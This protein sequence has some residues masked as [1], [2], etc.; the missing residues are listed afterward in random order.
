[1]QSNFLQIYSSPCHLPAFHLLPLGLVSARPCAVGLLEYMSGSAD[2]W[3]RPYCL[4]CCVSSTEELQV[5][6]LRFGL[7]SLT[8]SL[9]H[10]GIGS[11]ETPVSHCRHTLSPR[12]LAPRHFLFSQCGSAEIDYSTQSLSAGWEMD[13]KI[14]PRQDNTIQSF[15]DSPINLPLTVLL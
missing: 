7:D 6:G 5:I 1:M 3:I 4:D 15:T 10:S 14:L 13:H 11:A 9:T 8:H 2:S 12:I